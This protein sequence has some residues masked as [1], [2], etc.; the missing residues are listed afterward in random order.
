[1]TPHGDLVQF[2]RLLSEIRAVGL[3]EGQ[4]QGLCE[5]MDVEERDVRGLLSRAEEVWEKAKSRA[6]SA[7]RKRR[8][9]KGR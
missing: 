2:A 6:L 5:S 3:T 4:V 8:R 1:V 7:A 9:I